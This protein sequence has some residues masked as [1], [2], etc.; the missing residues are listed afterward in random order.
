MPDS[1]AR[2]LV[3]RIAAN[4]RWSRCDDRTAATAPARAAMLARFE[5]EVDPNGT[6]DPAERARRAEHKRKAWYQ[7]LALKSAQSRRKARE[8]T[9][10]A[11]A[12][13][14][15]LAAMDGEPDVAV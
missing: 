12:A 15:E 13:E 11:E 3:G 1:Q 10:A 5:R 14:A 7:R 9:S 8:L 4:E 6:L 2:S